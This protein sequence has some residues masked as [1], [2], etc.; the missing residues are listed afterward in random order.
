MNVLIILRICIIILL[1]KNLNIRENLMP[2]S[3]TQAFRAALD[4]KSQHSQ[5]AWQLPR[6]SGNSGWRNL[7]TAEE[8]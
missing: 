6:R 8:Y 1:L 4:Y 3:C 7:K 5:L 2:L